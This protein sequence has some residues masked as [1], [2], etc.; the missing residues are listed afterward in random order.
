VLRF[1]DAVMNRSCAT[2]FEVNLDT[3]GEG[4]SSFKNCEEQIFE[5]VV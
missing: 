3:L 5:V 4:G 1:G 2:V